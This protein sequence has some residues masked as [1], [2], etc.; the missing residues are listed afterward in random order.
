M[1]KPFKFDKHTAQIFDDMLIR[2]IPQYVEI[3]RMIVELTQKYA[4]DGTN[5]YD[6]GCSTGTTLEQLVKA[7]DGQDI[8]CIGV[9]ASQP[10]LDRALQKLKANVPNKNWSLIKY[11]LERD[12]ELTNPSVVI[13]NLT[14]QFLSLNVR[15]KLLANIYKSLPSNGC[16]IWIE[17]IKNEC[18]ELDELF[19]DIYYT[20]KKR[21][22]YTEAEIQEKRQALVNVLI[23]NT[24]PEN[25]QLL[26]RVGF[27]KSEEFFRWFNF[28]G[29]L[30]VK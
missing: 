26:K 2:S 21:N 14:I 24:F 16:F 1:V 17:K 22:H 25:E 18:P 23:P 19:V 4:K 29:L 28:N 30:A 13:S 15:E 8:S 3:Q 9:D 5:V 20:L 6:L 7:L 27:K 12:L 10:M 11:D